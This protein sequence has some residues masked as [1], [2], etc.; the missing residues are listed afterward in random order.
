MGHC[1]S[2]AGATC[3][4]PDRRAN[5]PLWEIALLPVFCQAAETLEDQELPVVSPHG[6]A[7]AQM[8]RGHLCPQQAFFLSNHFD[9]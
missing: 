4:L 2:K 6:F 3:S 1:S 5:D 8:E 9:L 7:A